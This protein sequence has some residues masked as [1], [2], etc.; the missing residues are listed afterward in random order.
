MLALP[1]FLAAFPEVLG[2]HASF[3]PSNGLAGLAG[4]LGS[5]SGGFGGLTPLSVLAT[6]LVALPDFL[7]AFLEVLG[8]LFSRKHLVLLASSGVN[9]GTETVGSL[10]FLLLMA[11]L[12]AFKAFFLMKRAS[13]TEG[14]AQGEE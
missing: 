5:L 9:D 6:A 7:A 8:G 3:R 4:F 10:S 11:A 13:L 1:D 2:G 14:T 12:D